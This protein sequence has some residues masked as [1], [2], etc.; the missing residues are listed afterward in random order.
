MRTWHEVRISLD[1][2]VGILNKNRTRSKSDIFSFQR[3]RIIAFINFKF[4]LTG[5]ITSLFSWLN[6]TMNDS[7]QVA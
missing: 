4:S 2:G 1:T 3:S 6:W 5:Y 7:V